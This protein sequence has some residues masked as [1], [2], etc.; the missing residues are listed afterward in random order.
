MGVQ[1][2]RA[3]HAQQPRPANGSG[4]KRSRARCVTQRPDDELSKAEMDAQDQAGIVCD[5]DVR[6]RATRDVRTS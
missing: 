3:S 6:T 1:A 5:K 4:S 2:S